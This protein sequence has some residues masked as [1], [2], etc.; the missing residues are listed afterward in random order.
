VLN[1]GSQG[2]AAAEEIRQLVD[3]MVELL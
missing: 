3:E 1:V 2:A